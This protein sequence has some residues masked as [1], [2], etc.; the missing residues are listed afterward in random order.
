MVGL[1][2]ADAIKAR[3][4]EIHIEAEKTMMRV[5]YRVEGVLR[6]QS[7]PPKKLHAVICARIKMLSKLDIAETR[8]PQE[9]Q[10]PIKIDERTG[11]AHVSTIGTVQ[12]ERVV[13][14]LEY[15]KA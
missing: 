13:V 1:I 4:T 10:F 9:G 5:R 11:V 7:P 3:A 2:L 12:G 8:L 14:R 15:P 6:E